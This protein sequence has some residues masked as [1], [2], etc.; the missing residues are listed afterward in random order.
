M[1]NSPQGCDL[2]RLGEGK[3]VP[4]GVIR[5]RQAFLMKGTLHPT[6]HQKQPWAWRP[7][8]RKQKL[9]QDGPADGWSASRSARLA[10][11]PPL[12]AAAPPGPCGRLICLQTLGPRAEGRKE[13]IAVVLRPRR[14]H[15]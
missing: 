13:D 5:G 7:D 10:E 4:E 6:P 1:P 9:R 2:E 15:T 12:A 14:E 11:A 8:Q 3:P